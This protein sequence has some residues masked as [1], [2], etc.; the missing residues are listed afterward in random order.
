[1]FPRIS[2]LFPYHAPITIKI[3][4]AVAV[5]FSGTVFPLLFGKQDLWLSFDRC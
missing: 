3:V 5:L 2:S 1:M 4:S